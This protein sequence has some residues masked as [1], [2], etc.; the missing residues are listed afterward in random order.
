M[1]HRND[2]TANRQHPSVRREK[3]ATAIKM[4]AEGATQREAAQAVGVSQPTIH[5][6]LGGRDKSLRGRIAQKIREELVCC[7]IYQRILDAAEPKL[8][9]KLRNSNNYHEICFF[10]EWAA[11]IAEDY[12]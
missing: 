2:G 8:Q 11:R 1:A 6:W 4:I 9:Q 3:I 5:Y 7:D 12:I 10:G